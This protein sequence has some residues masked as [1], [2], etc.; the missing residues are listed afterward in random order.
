MNEY[1]IYLANGAITLW[2]WLLKLLPFA[3]A[4]PFAL[5]A[6]L[7]EA[8][9][10]ITARPFARYIGKELDRPWN[11][12]LWESRRMA[13][14]LLLTYFL[15]FAV[16]VA[17]VEV[18]ARVGRAIILLMGFLMWAAA[19]I[20]AYL[21]VDQETSIVIRG[22]YSVLSYAALLLLYR[23]IQGAIYSVS[24]ADWAIALGADVPMAL[25]QTAAG[26]LHVMLILALLMVPIA[27]LS[28]TAQLYLVH[29]ARMRAD[30][31]FAKYQRRPQA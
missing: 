8:R 17:A 23:L 27:Y 5:Y 19:A 12:T 22:R 7:V 3:A 9:H 24:P 4:L 20:T 30:E 2:V 18:Y 26:W 11:R 21:V 25:G 10:D 6:M 14:R 29:R 31:A 1:L 15:T 13:L 16:W 28:W